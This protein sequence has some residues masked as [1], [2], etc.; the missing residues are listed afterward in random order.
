MKPAVL[1]LVQSLTPPALWNVYLRLRGFGSV[2]PWR[3]FGNVMTGA[4]AKPLLE[5][6]YSELYEKYYRLDPFLPIELTRYRNYNVCYF[7]SLCLDVP[8]DFLCAGVSWGITPRIVFDFT[9]FPSLGKTL[10]LIDP[11]EGIVANDSDK[12]SERYNRD[13]DFVLRQYPAGAPVKIHRERVPY[14]VPGQFAFIFSDTGN[15][16]ADAETMPIFYEQLSPGGIFITNSYANDIGYYEPVF[17]RL[18]VTPLWLPSGQGVV[19]KR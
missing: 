5:G 4:N 6:R 3:Q 14:K 1:N 15:A 17:A 18:G 12:V 10:H 7:A 13:P 9:D 2:Y 16:A 19:F 8:G 11:F